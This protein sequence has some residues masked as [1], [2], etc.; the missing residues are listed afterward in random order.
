MSRTFYSKFKS[1]VWGTKHTENT[2]V[3]NNQKVFRTLKHAF[4]RAQT[5]LKIFLM[6]FNWNKF[7]IP[8]K[9]QLLSATR[10]QL[11]ETRLKGEG[12]YTLQF[13]FV[14][15]FF[16]PTNVQTNQ[17][18]TL[19]RRLCVQEGLPLKSRCLFWV[20]F[21]IQISLAISAE[22]HLLAW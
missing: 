21:L 7:S 11:D 5:V 2:V 8:E 20:L 4:E 17:R 16:F 9:L 19:L 12:K 1:Y 14:V 18:K 22:L 15:R 10:S 3:V 6:F 13:R